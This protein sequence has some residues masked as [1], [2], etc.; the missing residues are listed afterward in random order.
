MTKMN[1]V[2]VSL[3]VHKKTGTATKKKNHCH[4]QM[5]TYPFTAFFVDLLM[6]RA[7]EVL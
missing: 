6:L 3:K 2:N 4:L 1:I 7:W 5:V